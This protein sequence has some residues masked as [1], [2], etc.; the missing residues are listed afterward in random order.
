MWFFSLFGYG[1]GVVVRSEASNFREGQ[2]VYSGSLSWEHYAVYPAEKLSVVQVADGVPISYYLGVLGMPG[3]TAWYGLKRLI[4]HINPGET[5]FVSA[6][7]GAVGSVVAQLAKLEGLKVIGSAG[8]ED[9]VAYIKD[10]LGIDVAFNYKTSDASDVLSKHGPIDVY[11]DNTNGPQLD[12]AL[13]NANVGG[14][15]VICGIIHNYARS[16]RYGIKNTSF[17]LA[18]DLTVRGLQVKLKDPKEFFD[19][20]TPLVQSGKIKYKET[21]TVGLE[22]AGQALA[23]LLT[24]GNFGKAIVVVAEK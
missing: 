16:E 8:R 9:K 23:D 17:I 6:A 11:F 2:F 14:R 15:F 7:S 13:A 12:A 20:V 10:E 4:S 22:H 19:A 5:L 24:G 18:R 21:H 1:I 3:Q